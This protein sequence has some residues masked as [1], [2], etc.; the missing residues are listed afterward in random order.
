VT[1]IDISTFAG[2]LGMPIDSMMQVAQRLAQRHLITLRPICAVAP[3]PFGARVAR[4]SR[5][6]QRLRAFLRILHI[7]QGRMP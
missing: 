2:R 3:T 5:R 7:Q 6:Q 1:P 4:Y